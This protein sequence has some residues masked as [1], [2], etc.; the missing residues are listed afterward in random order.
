MILEIPQNE[1][2]ELM[3]RQLRSFFT[4][5]NGEINLISVKTGG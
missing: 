1:I 5:S 2:V 3:G 4:L